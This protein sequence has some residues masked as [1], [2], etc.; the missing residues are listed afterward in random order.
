MYLL[1]SI[2]A[3]IATKCQAII[4]G[5]GGGSE[6]NCVYQGEGTLIRHFCIHY[7]DTISWLFLF[8]NSHCQCCSMNKPSARIYKLIGR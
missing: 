4:R 1:Y 7:A 5:G 2:I 6:D 3:L 8:G